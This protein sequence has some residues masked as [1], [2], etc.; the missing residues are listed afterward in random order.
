MFKTGA[1]MACFLTASNHTAFLYQILEI[2]M[3][4]ASLPLSLSV[5]QWG[6]SQPHVATVPIMPLL[7]IKSHG[8]SDHTPLC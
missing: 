7:L 4:L 8:H 3:T 6:L 2:N 1:K 5:A